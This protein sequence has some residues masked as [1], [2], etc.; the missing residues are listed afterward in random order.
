MQDECVNGP[1]QMTQPPC[2]VTHAR[3]TRGGVAE[4][5]R[6]QLGA[7]SWAEFWFI[8]ILRTSSQLVAAW[9][10]PDIL[11]KR[12]NRTNVWTSA[13]CVFRT[14]GVSS[15]PPVGLSCC[16]DW[17]LS[18]AETLDNR[19]ETDIIL[20]SRALLATGPIERRGGPRF[21]LGIA[22]LSLHVAP[23]CSENAPFG[24]RFSGPKYASAG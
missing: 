5:A 15:L 20:V 17:S 22:A 3:I 9:E 14:K 18:H 11:D 23:L 8:R 12:V 1:C 16:V 6:I 4:F 10:F 24:C 13:T 2:R 21:P 19:W 7:T